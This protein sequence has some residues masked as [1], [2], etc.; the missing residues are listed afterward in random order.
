MFNPNLSSSAAN[1]AGNSDR[2]GIE[3]AAQW[4]IS[5][6]LSFSGSFSDI[7]SEDDTG[8]QEIRVPEQTASL[9]VN[10]QS[11]VTDGFQIGAALDYVGE[12]DDFFFTFPAERVTLDSYTLASFTVVYP[13][14]ERLS[15]TLRGQNIF[16]EDVTD[17]FGF[18]QPGAQFFAGIRL[19]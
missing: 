3:L 8:A 12:Q 10:W 19:R 17:V 9:A 7:S 18:E 6:S 5:D 11:P 14:T 15:L 4:T 1:R 16:D 13:L 2:D